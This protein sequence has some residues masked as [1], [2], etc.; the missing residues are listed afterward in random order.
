M[1]SNTQIQQFNSTGYLNGGKVLD[2]ATVETLRA[3]V[4][5]MIEDRED[6]SVPQ[7]VLL[8]NLGKSESAP[9]WQ[10]VNAWR[11]S[12]AFEA[13]IYHPQIVTGIAELTGASEL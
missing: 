5:R 12:A 2:A 6:P 8:H 11:A 9:V 13:L 10:I 1:L 7:P 3:E 4:M